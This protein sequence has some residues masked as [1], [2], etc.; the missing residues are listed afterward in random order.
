MSEL[1]KVAANHVPSY[2][3]AKNPGDFFYV[4]SELGHYR[5]HLHFRC[6]CGCGIMAGVSLLPAIENGWLWNCNVEKPT[7]TPSIDINRG[8][9]H[10]YLTAGIF[11]EC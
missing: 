4:I 5:T 11:E 8:H 1:K 10:G 3:E 2:Y 7:I 6:P 9:W